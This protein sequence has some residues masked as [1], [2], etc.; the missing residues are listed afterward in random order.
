M[1]ELTTIL[2]GLPTTLLVTMASLA[3]GTVI[4]IPLMFGLRSGHRLVWLP[5][6]LVVDLCRGI[7]PIVWLF[8]L[9][10]GFVI[11]D[12]RFS[13]FEAGV[14][15][16]G[17]VAGVYLAEIFRG[18]LLSINPGQ[19]EASHA[20]GLSSVTT[21]VSIIG[22]QAWRTAIPGYTSYG[23]ALLKDS[24]IVST[25]GVTDVLEHA[26]QL[27]RTSDQGIFVFAVAAAVYVV[28]SWP[29]GVASRAA[30]VRLRR[31]VSR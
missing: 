6:R 10:Y 15:A 24:A 2:A 27:A 25:I 29:L 28:I 5:C 31:A 30:D 21:W 14:L 16:L 22:P 9:F 23:I 18:A 3:L 11:G 17:V 12:F 1:D 13:A 7:P 4:A 20:L 8:L 19:F 26:A